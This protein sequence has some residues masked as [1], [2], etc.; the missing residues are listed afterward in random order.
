MGASLSISQTVSRHR[1]TSSQET[2]K[3][4]GSAGRKVTLKQCSVRIA[5]ALAWHHRR[6]VRKPFCSGSSFRH[7]TSWRVPKRAT[8][9]KLRAVRS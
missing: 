7:H 6:R 8:T 3:R 5:G 9:K 1:L 2:R 4:T